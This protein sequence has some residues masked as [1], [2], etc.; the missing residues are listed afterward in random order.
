M[1]QLQREDGR[2]KFRITRDFGGYVVVYVLFLDFKSE[3][4]VKAGALTEAGPKPES[5]EVK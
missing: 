5:S 2:S 4:L 1:K 3:G